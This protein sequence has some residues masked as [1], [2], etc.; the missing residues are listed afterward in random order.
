[1]RIVEP[2]SPDE[3]S[4][5]R[6]HSGNLP[7]EVAVPYSEDDVVHR[8][9]ALD[10]NIDPSLARE[11]QARDALAPHSPEHTLHLRRSNRSNKGVPPLRYG[12]G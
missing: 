6:C 9:D 8:D 10:P 1:M 4:R 7:V 12:C 3:N 11:A 2:G 5:T